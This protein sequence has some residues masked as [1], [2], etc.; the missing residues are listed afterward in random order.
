MKKILEL[1]QSEDDTSLYVILDTNLMFALLQL[2]NPTYYSDNSWLIVLHNKMENET[3]AEDLLK[4]I[5]SPCTF[6]RL[7]SRLYFLVID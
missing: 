4:N 3:S 6:L 2:E 7:D 5:L 1:D